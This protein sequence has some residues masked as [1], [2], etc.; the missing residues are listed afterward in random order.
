MKWGD[1]DSEEEEGKKDDSKNELEGGD[2]KEEC[3]WRKDRMDVK[4]Y[5]K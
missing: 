2:E 5:G 1:R 4:K 3:I